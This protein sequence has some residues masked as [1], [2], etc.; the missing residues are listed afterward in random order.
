MPASPAAT[1]ALDSIRWRFALWISAVLIASVGVAFV[2]IYRES[3]D[4]LSGQIASDLSAD[5]TQLAQSRLIIGQGG[6]A[7][8]A[9]SGFRHYLAAQSF[10]S[11]STL[12]FVLVPGR[13]PISNYPEVFERSAPDEG[14]SAA[15]QD[16]ENR[17]AVA[18]A[19]PRLGTSTRVVGDVGAVR[20]LERPLEIDGLHLTIG[21]AEPLA[22]LARAQRGVVHSFLLAGLFIA[23]AVLMGSALVGSRV[24]APLRRMAAVATRVDA[25]DLEPRMELQG[26]GRD[27]VG[28]LAVAFNH[29]LDRLEAGFRGQREFIA[30]ASHELRTPLTVIQGQLEV[31]AN[32]ADVAPDEVR[33][34]ERLVNREIGRMRRIVDDLL[35]L[36]QAER[37]G[38]L[39]GETFDFERFVAE[40]W[41]GA[42]LVAERR[43]ELGPLPRGRLWGDPDRLAQALRNLINNAIDHTEAPQGL[44]R[45]QARALAP[46]SIAIEI[47]DDG[48]GIPDGEAER[49]FDR[50]HRTPESR[51]LDDRQTIGGAGL[52][53]SIVR[54][55]VLAHGGTVT[56]GNRAH[57][58]G[59][60][61]ELRLPGFEAQP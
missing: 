20:V 22:E 30:D 38:F 8:R 2:I 51:T 56:A 6:S 50:F 44:I 42:S 45:I 31:L 12:L 32:R 54:A 19:R 23:F 14:E 49:V 11:I 10:G 15:Q 57:H 26:G 1:R 18:I 29:M 47:T 48:P 24:T 36:A 37:P 9:L 59:A 39:K 25:G 33:R 40:I 52:G 17:L 58:H 3:S 46:S 61:F 60:R 43:F 35:L 4:R 34:V 41:D 7:T 16:A 55:I 13:E 28:V 21:A 5:T 27:E 53:L